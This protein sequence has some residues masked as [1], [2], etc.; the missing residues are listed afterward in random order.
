MVDKEGNTAL[1]LA[2]KNKQKECA[3]LLLEEAGNV[4]MRGNSAIMYAYQNN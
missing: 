2:L 1:I 4:D 3:M